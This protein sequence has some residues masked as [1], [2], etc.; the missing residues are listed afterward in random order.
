MKRLFMQALIVT[1]LFTFTFCP[2]SIA[3]DAT[4]NNS[5]PKSSS[6]Q[7]WNLLP[8]KASKQIHELQS[9]RMPSRPSKSVNRSPVHTKGEYIIKAHERHPIDR[10]NIEQYN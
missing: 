5:P 8:K 10:S 3:G 6:P 7:K 4:S 2:I 1:I 9:N